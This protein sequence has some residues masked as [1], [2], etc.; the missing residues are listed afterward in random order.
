MVSGI[1]EVA[2]DTLDR[3]RKSAP[4]LAE[5]ESKWFMDN[6]VPIYISGFPKGGGPEVGCPNLILLMRVCER[7]L[8]LK[9]WFFRDE[10]LQ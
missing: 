8:G 7:F 1:P 9:T 5:R 2:M 4:L 6:E 10:D 3:L